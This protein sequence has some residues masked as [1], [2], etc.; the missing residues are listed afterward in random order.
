[1]KLL[2]S[3][4]LIIL[5]EAACGRSA[6]SY[7]DRGNILFRAGKYQEAEFQYRASISKNPRFAEA[8]HRL[9][10]ADAAT[11]DGAA[12]LHALQQAQE[13]APNNDQYGIAL[14][15]LSL[16]AYQEDPTDKKLYDQVSREAYDLLHRNPNSCDGLRLHAEVLIIDREYD[17]ALAELRKAD[18]LRPLDPKVDVTMARALFAENRTEEAE[19][20]AQR[21]LAAHSDSSPMYD[22][23]INYYSKAHRTADAEHLLQAE[24]AGLPKD[25]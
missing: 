14:A 4:I 22:L 17:E 19:S 21:L 5:I 24:A 10:L 15:D 7:L 23:L 2:A 6:Q 20:L 3:A 18:A 9:G 11:G 25:V 1:M 13:F 8:Y 12:A 16:E